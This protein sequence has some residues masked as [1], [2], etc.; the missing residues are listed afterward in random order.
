MKIDLTNIEHINKLLSI[1]QSDKNSDLSPSQ[2]N[3]RDLSI[4][5]YNT[6]RPKDNEFNYIV[7]LNRL[8][9]ISGGLYRLICSY[10]DLIALQRD[11]K[12]NQIGI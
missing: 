8:G 4:Y 2:N 5:L 10:D 12:L 1:I 11:Y 6:Y 3:I 9:V 7:V